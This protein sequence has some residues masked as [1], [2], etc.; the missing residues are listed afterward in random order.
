MGLASLKI[1]LQIMCHSYEIDRCHGQRSGAVKHSLVS[2]VRTIRNC[3]G[4][5][6]PR[7]PT[8]SVSSTILGFPSV[9]ENKKDLA[10]AALTLKHFLL[11]PN[12][13][14]PLTCVPSWSE[15]GRAFS[16]NPLES[17]LGFQGNGIT[18]RSGSRSEIRVGFLTGKIPPGLLY[19]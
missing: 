12:Q 7:F 2:S 19:Q 1:Q 15:N 8:A 4:I 11:Q 14:H 17:S 9:F 3:P 5:F 13:R 10:I 18:Q 16:F 6:C